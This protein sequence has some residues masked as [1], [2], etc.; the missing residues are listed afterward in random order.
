MTKRDQI[1]VLVGT[2]AADL[3]FR[4]TRWQLVSVV[5]AFPIGEIFVWLAA[6]TRIEWLWLGV[7]LSLAGWLGFLIPGARLAPRASR[8]ASEY[9]SSSEGRT[10]AVK[11]AG[12]NRAAWQREIARARQRI[13]ADERQRQK[14]AASDLG[15]QQ[16]LDRAQE[17]WDEYR[18]RHP[19]DPGR[20]D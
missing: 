13:E 16:W 19:Q 4:A 17:K 6:A 10:I 5:F 18:R 20:G 3:A 11:S 1:A 7:L 8:A 9:L 2:D 14:Q 12:R 15:N